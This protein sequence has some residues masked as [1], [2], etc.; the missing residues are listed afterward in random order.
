MSI[1]EG[2]LTFSGT[3]DYTFIGNKAC[4]TDGSSSGGAIR[5]DAD[6]IVSTMGLKPSP[7]GDTFRFYFFPVTMGVWKI[8]GKVRTV[9]SI[10]S[11]PLF[12]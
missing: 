11:F 5:A 4:G 1:T 12:G 10:S 9:A 6:L 2:K 8:T 7:S 3:G